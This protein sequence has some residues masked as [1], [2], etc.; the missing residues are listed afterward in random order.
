MSLDPRLT[1]MRGDIALAGWEDRVDAQSF[2]PGV[3][4]A[5]VAP[6]LDLRSEREATGLATQL[7]YGEI[8]NV[9]EVRDGLALGQSKTDGYVGYVSADGLGDP[10]ASNGTVTA[11]FAQL[12]PEPSIKSVPMGMVPWQSAVQVSGDGPFAAMS[13]GYLCRQHLNGVATDWVTEAGR[14]LGAPYLWGGRSPFGLDCSALVQLALA[15]LGVAAPRDSDMQMDALGDMLPDSAE[16]KRGDLI[17]WK[18]HVGI[19]EDADTL[20][21][22]TAHWMA[23]VREPLAPAIARIAAAG[24]G[25]VL[26]RKR[27]S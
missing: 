17:F 8:F 22:A 25:P 23:V 24:D 26:A 1:P 21:H 15:A 12:Y 4:R 13:N 11:L 18:G 14:L 5:V 9:F 7:I 19:M 6:V 16:L 2:V 20:L 10:V 3:A 27:I